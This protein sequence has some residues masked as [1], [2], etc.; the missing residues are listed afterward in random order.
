M[1]HPNDNAGFLC[2]ECGSHD[3][4]GVIMV[5]PAFDDDD[6]KPWSA[7]LQIITC[8]CCNSLMPAHLAE[9]W[10][11]I[12]PDEAAKEWRDVYRNSMPRDY[13]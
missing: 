4:G 9:L 6:D 5:E 12:S 13:I 11:G 8:A 7:V 10:D 2:P 3:A 1:S